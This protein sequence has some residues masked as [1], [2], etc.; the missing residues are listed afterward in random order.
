MTLQ[1]TESIK[2]IIETSA[3]ST[4]KR[5]I[6]E[7][8]ERYAERGK[9]GERRH[10]FFSPRIQLISNFSSQKVFEFLNLATVRAIP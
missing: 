9:N 7:N 1:P 6:L 5:A 3:A 2:M 8:S 4:R 10:G